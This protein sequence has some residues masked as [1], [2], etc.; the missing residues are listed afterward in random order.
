MSVLLRQRLREQ[1]LFGSRCIGG[2]CHGG[3]DGSSTAESF[4]QDVF[5]PHLDKSVAQQRCLS[6]RATSWRAC[7]LPATGCRSFTAKAK[8]ELEGGVCVVDIHMSSVMRKSLAVHFPSIDDHQVPVCPPT[9]DITWSN[10]ELE[11]A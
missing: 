3:R 1:I 5:S 7:A 2:A 8:S 10:H 6:S 9:S 11:D 4:L